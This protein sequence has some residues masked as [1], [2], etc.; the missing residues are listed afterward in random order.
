MI[1]NARRVGATGARGSSVRGRTSAPAGLLRLERQIGNAAVTRLV[2]VDG[3]VVQRQSRTAP[4]ALEL[5]NYEINSPDRLVE[6][7][8]AA[9]HGAGT[10]D[11][12]PVPP[13]PSGGVQ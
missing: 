2:A 9:L 3:A 1:T 8:K 10:N 5:L 4:A 11:V 6:L 12:H 7:V 13:V